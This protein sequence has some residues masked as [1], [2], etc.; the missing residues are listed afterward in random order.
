MVRGSGY[1][2]LQNEERVITMSPQH[3]QRNVTAVMKFCPTCNRET[4][5]RVSDRRVGSCLNIHAEGMSKKQEA[6]LRKEMKQFELDK[7]NEK[8]NNLFEEDV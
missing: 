6:Q 5:H 7:K 1:P 2:V 3:Y 8:Q 4:M